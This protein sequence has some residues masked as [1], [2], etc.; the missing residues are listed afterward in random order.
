MPIP[1]R[2]Q[3][4]YSTFL[5]NSPRFPKRIENSQSSP[6]CPSD[7][8]NMYSTWRWVWSVG[9]II[10]T[11]ESGALVELYWQGRVERWWNYTDR[12]EWNV[13]GIILT[14]ESGALVEL[15]W[16]GRAERW[17]NYTDR[18]ECSVGGI[19]LTGEKRI[20][21]TIS[22]PNDTSFSTNPSGTDNENPRK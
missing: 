4:N 2:P 19:I 11:G 1:C 17:W 15:Y 16:Q 18:G 10:P 5:N 3:Q 12:G 8:R 13:G 21:G 9:G 7:N 14:G 22:C 20:T 6:A